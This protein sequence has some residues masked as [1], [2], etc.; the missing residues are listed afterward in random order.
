[1]KR[2]AISLTALV[3]LLSLPGIAVPAG[4]KVSLPAEYGL[5]PSGVMRD[6]AYVESEGETTNAFDRTTIEAQCELA[7]SLGTTDR[8]PVFEPGYDK[9]LKTENHLFIRGLHRA[10]YRTLHAYRCDREPTPGESSTDYACGCTYRVLPLRTAHIHES[11]SV[12]YEILRID[13]TRRTARRES[14]PSQALPPD[15]S[16]ELGVIKS[17]APEVVAEEVVAGIPCVVRRHR[18]SKT[19]WTDLCIAEDDA[20]TLPPELRMRALSEVTSSKVGESSHAWT[21]AVRVVPSARVDSTVFQLPEGVVTK[22][23]KR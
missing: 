5:E 17:Y 18:S 12:R 19:A 11:G 10:S 7:R 2:L 14:G 23:I 6:A 3:G 13:L 21:K 20:A 15:A 9:P 1:M 8:H 22:D 16:R 4:V